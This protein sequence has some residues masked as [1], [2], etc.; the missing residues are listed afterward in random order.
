[1]YVYS[2]SRSVL[3]TPRSILGDCVIPENRTRAAI[4]FRNLV[5]SRPVLYYLLFSSRRNRS[6]IIKISSTEMISRSQSGN[7][8]CE[9][10]GGSYDFDYLNCTSGN[11]L[12]SIPA[13][14]IN[15]V[16][17][18]MHTEA[19]VPLPHVRIDNLRRS[20]FTFNQHTFPTATRYET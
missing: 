19:Y 12:Q 13:R 10:L 2:L 4:Q 6:C 5:V 3:K 11:K 14:C 17:T 8:S 20:F 18:T 1:M 7:R 9:S 16:T 15:V